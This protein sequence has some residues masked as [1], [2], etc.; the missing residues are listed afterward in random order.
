MKI[1]KQ[2]K[3]NG[4]GKLI[5]LFLAAV[6]MF[7]GIVPTAAAS[8][9][10][11]DGTPDDFP[12]CSVC[13]MDYIGG[14]RI[15]PD[16]YHGCR[17]AFIPAFNCEVT[18]HNVYLVVTNTD[19]TWTNL[20]SSAVTINGDGAYELS[21]S[22]SGGIPSTPQIFIATEGLIVDGNAPHLLEH[23]TAL[24]NLRVPTRFH[25][26]V[27]TI[28][29]V[30]INT[31]NM[32]LV[33]IPS[34][35]LTQAGWEAEAHAVVDIY[36]AWYAPGNKFTGGG[37]VPTPWQ[38]DDSIANFTLANNARINTVRVQFTISNTADLCPDCDKYRCECVCD[39]CGG[40]AVIC[41]CEPC[42]DCGKDPCECP[43]LCEDC[44]KYPCECPEVCED[45]GKDPCECP[46][47]CE[48][49]GKYPCECP[50]CDCR[51]CEDCGHLGGKFGFGNVRG[52][53]NDDGTPAAPDV[54]DALAILRQLVGL[55]SVI[56]DNEDARIAA[57]I[58]TPGAEGNPSV[59]DAL[60]ILRFLVGLS[61][62]ID[63][64]ARP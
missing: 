60:Q 46:E 40:L 18:T 14:D 3:K 39:N 47:P 36:N 38:D 55:L 5:A 41:E 13:G 32:S 29:Q 12:V 37:R 43:E 19:D 30:R 10:I 56:D 57:N 62:M 31:T 6:M 16:T 44:D 24:N 63:G 22:I 20:T 52:R 45:C 58:V 53:T 35:P 27:I 50:E 42:E 54:Q 26:S 64:S 23:Y 4:W 8:P 28:T 17:C 15:V 48:D 49:C 21:L 11:A 34:A 61:N 25:N 59:Q 51:N 9:P 7:G 2:Q 33:E 1:Q